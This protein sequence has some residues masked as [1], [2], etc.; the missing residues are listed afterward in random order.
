MKVPEAVFNAQ[1]QAWR[2]DED[3]IKDNKL[4]FQTRVVVKD[5]CINIE[6]G[7][8]PNVVGLF[9]GNPDAM[10]SKNRFNCDLVDL[11]MVLLLQVSLYLLTV[12]GA[13]CLLSM[14]RCE[15]LSDFFC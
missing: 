6:G 4:L 11:P 1:C 13:S 10:G 14:L 7:G 3:Q 9:K 15:L 12:A 8:A 2:S 5:D